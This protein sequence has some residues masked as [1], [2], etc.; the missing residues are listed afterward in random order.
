MRFIFIQR[1]RGRERRFEGFMD[2]GGVQTIS[3]KVECCM[4]YVEY[5]QPFSPCKGLYGCDEEV[6]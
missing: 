1:E 5:A 3:E 6:E 2:G 4:L